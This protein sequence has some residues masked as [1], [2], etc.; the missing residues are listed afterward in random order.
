MFAG[1]RQIHVGEVR[2]NEVAKGI[3]L[4]SQVLR[5]GF[6]YPVEPRK[7]GSS[8]DSHPIQ[9]VQSLGAPTGWEPDSADDLPTL[10][11]AGRKAEPF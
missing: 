4:A 8:I 6:A 7:Q 5:G 10:S 2:G 11:H 3:R 1:L 9:G